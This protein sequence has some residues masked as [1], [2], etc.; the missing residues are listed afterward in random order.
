MTPT[1]LRTHAPKPLPSMVSKSR[2][3]PRLSKEE[4][5][6]LIKRWQTHRDRKAADKLTQCSMR[7]VVAVA[8]KHRRYNVSVD[9]LISEGS[10]GLVRAMDRL[11][12]L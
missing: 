12:L 1:T 6:E 11:G 5:R 2:Q 7:Y 9:V 8:Y 4:E 3:A 10:L